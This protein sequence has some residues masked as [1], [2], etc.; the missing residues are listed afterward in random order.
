MIKALIRHHLQHYVK[1][2]FKKHSPKLIVVVGAVGKTTTKTA[3]ATVAAQKFRVQMEPGNHNSELS[4]PLAILGVRFPPENM[5]RSLK[6]WR[7]VFKACRRRVRAEQGVDV[8]VQELGTDAPGQ[9]ARFGKYLNADIAVVTAIAEEH[10]EH[11]PGG[12]AD[13]AKE[14]LSVQNFAKML[15]VNHDDIDPKFAALVG[16]NSVTDYGLDGGEYRFAIDSVDA[17]AGYKAH[18]FAPEFGGASAEDLDFRET[19]QD[20][21]EVTVKVLGD[22]SVRAAVAAAAVGVKL[23]MTP[24]EIVR[25]VAEIRPVAGRMNPLRGFNDSVILDDT[26]NSQ[27]IAA[28]AALLTLYNLGGDDE[29]TKRHQQ[30]IAIFGSMNELGNFSQA[31]HEQVGAYC[32]PEYLD[33]VLTFGE[34]ANNYLA[35]AAEKNG[36]VVKRFGSAIEA[37]EFARKII[38]PHGIVLVKGSQNG[39][40]AERATELLLADSDDKKLLVRQSPEWI[41][42]KNAFFASLEKPTDDDD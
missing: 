14:E 35:T 23:G 37:G 32:D 39:V 25:G 4:V 36:C 40:F 22:P 17:R 26:Y 21:P 1:R 6:T 42:K 41:A 38:E 30:R 7:A 5:L 24:A 16:T 31:A 18:F 33:A 9:I 20:A 15:L 2:Y 3:I 11:F 10:M 28:M 29:Q 12:L 13:V 19:K 8:I 27:P 34:D